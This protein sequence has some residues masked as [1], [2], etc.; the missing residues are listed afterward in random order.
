[1]TLKNHGERD[2]AAAAEKVLRLAA[3]RG[4]ITEGQVESTLVEVRERLQKA[5][6]YS[7]DE[8]SLEVVIPDHL[9]QDDT[10]ARLA[11]RDLLTQLG[12]QAS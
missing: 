9:L 4:Y 10:L 1:M 8:P 5:G 6:L 11:R 12:R 3:E 7:L 2:T